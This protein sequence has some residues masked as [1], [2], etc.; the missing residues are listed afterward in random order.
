LIIFGVSITAQAQKKI[1]FNPVFTKK[2]AGTYHMAATGAAITN[3]NDKYVLEETGKGTWTIFSQRKPDG[4]VSSAPLSIT[5]KWTADEG[6]IQICFSARK[7]RRIAPRT[8][9]LE[10][11]V[12]KADDAYLKKMIISPPVQ[13]EPVI[14]K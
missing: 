10:G 5:G 4:S 7:R 9:R 2:Y 8:F 3:E 11:D 14:K 12:F 1:P 13:R 6:V